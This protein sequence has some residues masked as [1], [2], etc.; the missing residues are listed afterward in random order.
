MLLPPTSSVE[1]AASRLRDLPTGGRTPLAAGIERAVEVLEREGVR[2]R[3]RRPLLVLLTDG[4]ATTGPDPRAAAAQLRSLGATCFVVDTE[5]AFVRLGMAVEL[6]EAM[7]AR[8]LRLEE[9]RAGALVDLVERRRV[10]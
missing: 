9:L 7:G 5:E 1:L 4:R 8:C 10:A 6:A 3:E 2:D